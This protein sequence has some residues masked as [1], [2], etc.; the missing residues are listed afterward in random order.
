MQ[1]KYCNNIKSKV[2]YVVKD[3]KAATE[4]LNSKNISPSSEP[5][6]KGIFPR[7]EIVLDDEARFKSQGRKTS[8]VSGGAI[9]YKA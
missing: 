5:K 9:R 6:L 3:C 1:L 4:I 2:T 7:E 8:L